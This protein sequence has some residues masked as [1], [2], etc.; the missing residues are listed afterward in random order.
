MAPPAAQPLLVWDA[1]T[2]EYTAKPGET[3]NMFVFSVTNAGPNPISIEGLKP[4]CGCTVAKLPHQPWRLLPGEGGDTHITINFAGKYGLVTK[5]IRVDASQEFETQPTQKFVQTLMIKVNIPGQP[6]APASLSAMPA[7]GGKMDRTANVEM[8]KAD[9]QAVFK[10]D[11]ASCHAVP[12]RGKMGEQLYTVACAICHDSPNRAQ[13]V[14]E[15]AHLNKSTDENFWRGWISFGKGG[16][17]MPG[18]ADRA[19]G[20]LTRQQIDS[21]AVFLAKKYPSPTIVGQLK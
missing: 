21:L 2:K 9:R 7:P 15:L 1:M 10:G 6:A 12:T 5:L 19:G 13:M 14:P 8:A 18:F 3:T 11:C 4:S 16:T 17:L 20:P